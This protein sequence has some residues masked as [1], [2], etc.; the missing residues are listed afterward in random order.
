[1]RK[2]GSRKQEI[3]TPDNFTNSPHYPPD[4]V[5]LNGFK[6]EPI[7]Y[8][9][10]DKSD[11]P[12][13][14]VYPSP[15]PS[16]TENLQKDSLFTSE[17]EES[18]YAT[19]SHL[20]EHKKSSTLL[21]LLTHQK[22][23]FEHLQSNLDLQ[24]IHSPVRD[25][26][27]SPSSSQLKLL[28]TTHSVQPSTLD[29][30]RENKDTSQVSVVSN[31]DNSGSTNNQH[32]HSGVWKSLRNK[33]PENFIPAT[34]HIS[35]AKD[36]EKKKFFQFGKRKIKDKVTGAEDTNRKGSYSSDKGLVNDEAASYQPKR[37]GSDGA[38]PRHH[39]N[40]E[41]D[42]HSLRGINGSE[43]EMD[44]I[45]HPEVM[46]RANSRL[47]TASFIEGLESSM[48]LEDW[49]NSTMHKKDLS[50]AWIPPESWAVTLPSSSQQ[51]TDDEEDYQEVQPAEKEQ[52]AVSSEPFCI[53]IFR[54]DSTFGTVTIPA[55]ITAAEL[56]EILGRKF[57]L[58]EPSKYNLYVHRH[59]LVRILGAQ[60][61]PIQYLKR[62]LEQMGYT[63]KDKLRDQGRED[64]TY[65]CRFTFS[66]TSLQASNVER[67]CWPTSFQEVDL[68]SR[69]LQTVPILLFRHASMIVTL[70]LSKNLMLDIPSDFIQVCTSLM[71]LKLRNNEY[72][73]I[74]NGIRYAN[75]LKCLDL[76]HNRL[77]EVESAQLHTITSLNKLFLLNN[78]IR[79]LPM[80]FAKLVNLT[81]LDVSNN[82]L[83]E[84]PSSVCE[85]ISIKELN[86]SFNR[87]YL[88]P[89]SIGK[90][91]C[92][93]KLHLSCN[94]ICGSLPKGFRNLCELIELDIRRNK[95]HDLD[96]LDSLP[97]LE[98]LYSDNNSISNLTAKFQSLKNLTLSKNHLTQFSLSCMS[99]TLTDLN[100]S[101]SKL[102][103]LPE[104]IFEHLGG[105][106]RLK[107]DNNHLVSIPSCIGALKNLQILNCTNNL[108]GSLPVEI[109]GL[110]DLR[111]L[112]VHNNNLKTLPEEF[113]WCSRLIVLNASSNL[114][115]TL[116]TP[117]AF[118]PTFTSGPPTSP[119]TPIQ[120]RRTENS[121]PRTV[122]PPL[123]LSLQ[124]LMLG[125]NRL[126]DDIFP[127]ISLLTELRVLNVS[128]N[129][130]Y[131]IPPKT[132]FSLVNLIELY[133]SGNQI[134]S[135]PTDE[136]ERLRSLR[137][138]HVNAN[139]LHTLPAELGKIGKLEVLDVGSNNLKYNIS[140]WPYDWNWNWNLELRYLNLSG[141]KRLQ[142]KNNHND[143]NPNRE[144]N[145]A[146]FSSLHVLSVLGLMDVALMVGVPEE[147]EKRRIRTSISEAN[148]MSY[149]M[150]DY[151]GP[152]GVLCS[153]DLAVPKFRS[154]DNEC[155]FALFD[156]LN[157]KQGGSVFS[158]YLNDWFTFHFISE[159]KKLR[160]SSETAED[161]L[162]RT[163]LG[164]E[165]ELGTFAIEEGRNAGASALVIYICDKTL[166][167]AN[168][169]DALAVISRGNS[170]QLISTRHS[171]W[172]QKEI[173]RIRDSGGWISPNGLVGGQV[174]VSRCF[175]QFN[176]LPA[177]NAN[178]TIQ[179][180]K[181]G[182][183]DEFVIMASKGL[184]DYVS[185]QTAVDIARTS[186]FDL[187]LAAQ[188]LRDFAITY[189]ASE[190]IVVMI[191]GVGDLFN[192]QPTQGK[193]GNNHQGHLGKGMF[194]FAEGFDET[195]LH[196]K[197]HRG[198]SE[199]PGDG[200]LARLEREI[201]PPVGTV[202]LVFTDIK[203]STFLWETLPKA[204]N[205]AIR[206]HNKIMRRLLRT[207]G[208]YEVKT[209]GDAFMVSFPTVSSALR[210]CLTVQLQLLQ[211]DWPQEILNSEDGREIFGPGLTNELLYRGLSV[212]MGIHYGKPVHEE[213]PITKRMDYFGPMVNRSARICSVADGGQI[214]VSSDVINEINNL[215]GIFDELPES[216]TPED[217]L[218]TSEFG[219]DEMALRK[220]RLE[221]VQLGKRKL[222]GLETPEELSLIYPKS[223][224]ARWVQWQQAQAKEE[225]V[226]YDKTFIQ[227]IDPALIRSLGYICIRLERM[228]SGDA[229][230]VS[231]RASR[232]DNLSGLLTFHVKDNAE[233]HELMRIMEGLVARIENAYSTIY[234]KRFE[235]IT[236]T[237]T[238]IFGKELDVGDINLTDFRKAL[239]QFRDILALNA[240]NA[241]KGASVCAPSM[242]LHSTNTP[243][244]LTNDTTKQFIQK[245]NLLPPTAPN[246]TSSASFQPRNRP[247]GMVVTKEMSDPFLQDLASPKLIKNRMSYDL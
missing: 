51:D 230:L 19:S 61:R 173:N 182:E 231:R 242:A 184:W 98:R 60:E 113:W 15:S 177:I 161:A 233:D 241:K 55:H 72:K 149:G 50:E 127:P 148:H 172:S 243:N 100:L 43:L 181:L 27:K 238:D 6:S 130:I 99:D 112:D 69:N 122:P 147:T 103:R 21:S 156:S 138:L 142:I 70:N 152:S 84:F 186:R 89:E 167:V 20:P 75:N 109:A 237:V 23:P 176:M 236:N 58:P 4:C 180:V 73:H 91:V 42:L 9:T 90:L 66:H 31:Y 133:L 110:P 240:N 190:S 141:N 81:V 71:D 35:N 52:S 126:T 123:S 219:R 189:G 102:S 28:N 34:S 83:T 106:Q 3:T 29:M 228:A 224:L 146:D 12:D 56:C 93:E 217:D 111:V 120:P 47:H 170:A 39:K 220:L 108:L 49:G 5:P 16:Q 168:V 150:A 174:G 13:I 76:S 14:S 117:S 129:A 191:I 246:F 46:A 203:N 151:L 179:T 24:G 143:L 125:D 145:L 229:S 44:G 137:I 166:Y 234:L 94:Q 116:P 223:L 74:P 22:K 211:A 215:E 212:R 207:I 160:G 32:S 36:K 226:V 178:P 132:L 53:R 199:L 213:D 144:R 244:H 101:S 59:G 235:S 104:D 92:L 77:K 139:K 48:G 164:I 155:L 114:L 157:V 63:S 26:R 214:C 187:M 97:K 62:M 41:E 78:R 198:N 185:Y 218:S 131:E 87:L 124:K 67:E 201:Q 82:K 232:T 1:M 171:A 134:S 96:V 8:Y 183:H 57:F 202:A 86:L 163:F 188:K 38:W 7:T 169:G 128:F 247:L 204:M 33:I 192:R 121:L 159:L 216:D 11:L 153:W 222:K 210:W 239:E 227:T 140:N 54:E 64:N 200:T 162:R 165:K 158:K 208:G 68:P 115:E 17:I 105:L 2:L 225:P 175:G 45:V 88:L 209:E 107:L 85:L 40:S 18:D 197:S 119:T 25:L 65:L 195:N 37:R 196:H 95:I 245:A 80:E 194:G 135:L 30:T 221:V 193:N 79:T 10:V 136:I 205:N 154:S 206:V 118:P